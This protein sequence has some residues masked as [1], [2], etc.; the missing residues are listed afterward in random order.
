[1]KTLLERINRSRNAKSSLTPDLKWTI[2]EI[3]KFC[4]R[5]GKA[6]RSRLS[7]DLLS[8][9]SDLIAPFDDSLD[10]IQFIKST[11]PSVTDRLEA[12]K[13]SKPSKNAFEMM[14]PKSSR[15]AS[16]S[17]AAGPS[18]PSSSRQ[19]SP[20]DVD[21]YDDFFD[22]VSV[23][24]LAD[25]ERKA[26]K[27][28]QPKP[29]RPVQAP[30]MF[31]KLPPGV[32]N[33]VPKLKPKLP[34]AMG[35]LKTKVMKD[36]RREHV[37]HLAERRKV[38]PTVTPRLPVAPVV[39]NKVLAPTGIV[40]KDPPKPV[41]PADSGSSA[42]DSSDEET[43]T[44]SALTKLQKSPARPLPEK[45]QVK[46]LQTSNVQNLSSRGAQ[47][48]NAHRTRLRLRPDLGVLHRHILT[49]DPDFSG[50]LAPQSKKLTAQHALPP[51]VRVP[52]VFKDSAAYEA[53]MLPLFIQE[54]WASYQKER[55]FPD[56]AIGV[57]V[58]N[59]FYVDE[60]VDLELTMTGEV[61]FQWRANETDVMILRKIGAPG[62][63]FAKVQNFRRKFKEINMTLRVHSSCD[64][65]GLSVRSKWQMRRAF[66]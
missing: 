58:S 24:D 49:W 64:L 37:A 14:M 61:P 52:R 59:R 31:T 47:R 17:P 2:E 55:D 50:A 35:G 33:P 27:A 51:M 6:F 39:P 43:G 30:L 53:V 1:M 16:S 21:A 38:G 4:R 48:Q 36:L 10:E 18:K 12:V 20:I 60:Y 34:S 23:G 63:L 5:D 62:A 66:S 45:R 3:D 56:V 9:L 42:S 44:I 28:V 57:E 40:R 15:T 13:P 25:L 54:Q 29:K 26:A 32:K 7:D 8:E 41:A 46:V 22:E 65:A 11:G 19:P